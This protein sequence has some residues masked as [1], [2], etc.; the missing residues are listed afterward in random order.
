[1]SV[2]NLGTGIGR[3]SRVT[4]RSRGYRDGNRECLN[5]IVC[6]VEPVEGCTYV[7]E[8]LGKGKLDFKVDNVV[9]FEAPSN[10]A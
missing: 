4:L 10:A 3:G 6:K 9:I 2:W 5:C 1:M 8:E 7:D